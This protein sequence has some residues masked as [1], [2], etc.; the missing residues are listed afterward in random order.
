MA[1]QR[2][3]VGQSMVGGATDAV[4]GHQT[5]HGGVPT[6]SGGTT[7]SPRPRL[8]GGAVAGRLLG[9]VVGDLPGA[10]RTAAGRGQ[11]VAGGGR[12]RWRHREGHQAAGGGRHRR[13]GLLGGE[14]EVLL[15]EPEL[16]QVLLQTSAKEVNLV[17][18]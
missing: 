1:V 2:H 6:T 11:G 15:L 5:V 7:V 10:R 18:Y 8:H 12:R 13:R 9:R 4:A 3:L 16:F 17:Y 14:E